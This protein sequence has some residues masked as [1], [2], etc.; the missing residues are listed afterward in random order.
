[1]QKLVETWF[2]ISL[3]D[4]ILTVILFNYFNFNSNYC[5][6]YF[7]LSGEHTFDAITSF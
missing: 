1:M 7:H 2:Y 3:K 5:K 4:E 6:I